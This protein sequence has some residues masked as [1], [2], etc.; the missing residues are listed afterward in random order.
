MITLINVPQWVWF[1]VFLAGLIISILYDRV[2]RR[3]GKG[4]KLRISTP[5]FESL[6]LLFNFLLV[7]W[8]A[9]LIT[10]ITAITSGTSKVSVSGV[11]ALVVACFVFEIL[12]YLTFGFLVGELGFV[13]TQGINNKRKRDKL[14][15]VEI[16]I[17]AERL[18]SVSKEIEEYRKAKTSLD[19]F[20]KKLID[21]GKENEK[22]KQ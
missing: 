14:D 3:A 18:E 19:D 4:I 16:N 17:S 15:E 10:G 12:V 2:L 5:R 8:N 7:V 11:S 22:P 1:L 20:F 9:A 13:F 6:I 21:A